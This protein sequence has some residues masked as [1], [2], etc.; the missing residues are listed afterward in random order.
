MMQLFQSYKYF[1]T[2]TNDSTGGL[3]CSLTSQDSLAVTVQVIDFYLAGLLSLTTQID[4][5]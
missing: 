5:T 2:V 4:T 1:I 3:Y